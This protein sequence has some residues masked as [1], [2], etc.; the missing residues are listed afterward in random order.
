MSGLKWDPRTRDIQHNYWDEL[1]LKLEKEGAEWE[2][3][4]WLDEFEQSQASGTFDL[5]KKGVGI[6]NPLAG[7]ALTTVDNLAES[8]RLER[9]KDDIDWDKYENFDTYELEKAQSDAIF[10]LQENL[11]D[12]IFG[13]AYDAYRLHG[14]PFEELDEKGKVIKEGWNKFVPWDSDLFLDT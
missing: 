2:Y 5:I 10:E 8:K 13:T 7:I 3:N 14:S 11:Y 1:N 12:E 9:M 6:F 4:K